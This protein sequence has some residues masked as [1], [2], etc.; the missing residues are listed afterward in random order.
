MAGN[1]SHAHCQHAVLG[2]EHSSR[3][4][5]GEWWSLTR[6]PLDCH[7]VV[8]WPSQ[9]AVLEQPL[10]SLQKARTAVPRQCSVQAPVCSTSLAFP[11]R[12]HGESYHQPA[13]SSVINVMGYRPSLIRFVFVIKQRGTTVL[14]LYHALGTKGKQKQI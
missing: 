1:A 3:P 6:T 12:P 13:A 2:A 14:D 11:A 4:G 9:S 5:L 10:A 8:A 7:W